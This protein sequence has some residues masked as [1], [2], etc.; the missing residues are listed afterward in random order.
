MSYMGVDIGTTGC[1]AAVFDDQGSLAALA[2]RE[3]PLTSPKPTWAQIDSAQVCQ[4]AFEVIREAAISAAK[5]PVRAL[6]ISCQGE[7]FTPVDANGQFLGHAM[8]SSDSRAASLSYSWSDQFGHF[9]LYALTGHTPHPMFTIFKLLWL[10]QNCPEVWTS[11]KHFYCFEELL[12]SRLGVDPAISWPLAG[13]TMMFNIRTHQW[14]Q[15]ILAAADIQ[16]SQLARPVPSGTVVGTIPPE[17]ADQLGLPDGVEVVA[18]G[19]DQTCGALGAGVVRPGVAMYATGTVDCICPALGQATL[20]KNLFRNNLC[21]Y[22]YTAPG[23]YTTIAFSLTGG[24]LLR[25]YRDQWACQ[26]TAEAARSGADPYER[27]LSAMPGEPTDLLVLPYFTPS[28]TPYFDAHTPGAIFGLRLA[29]TRP[30]VLRA[31]LEGVAMEMRLNVEILEAAGVPIQEFRAIGGGA[32]SLALTQLKADVL[33]RPVTTMA[34]TEAGC[35]GAAML[36]CSAHSGVSLG[37][38]VDSW[39]KPTSVVTPDSQRAS[40]YSR[41]FAAYKDLY[42]VIRGFAARHRRDESETSK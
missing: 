18:G 22:D 5:D 10:R 17:I 36:A 41:N 42:P 31:L 14:E 20:E 35:L 2:Y 32:K 19:H 16:I 13:R 12:Q 27:I 6:A 15:E 38:L 34:V 25:W 11:A 1:K 24:N 39:V 26:E 4:A 3:Y 37:E 29:T 9:R 40:I 23:M 30:Q 8:V 28:G 33:G 7:A 21:T